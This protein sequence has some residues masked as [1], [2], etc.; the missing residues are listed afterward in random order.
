M[1]QDPSPVA[2]SS[3]PAIL[4]I[5]GSPDPADVARH[6][7]RGRMVRTPEG[8]VL[9]TYQ[10]PEM[11]IEDVSAYLRPRA[12]SF[13]RFGLDVGPP[14]DGNAVNRARRL[15]DNA[16]PR[17]LRASPAAAAMLGGSV[18]EAV[19]LGYRIRL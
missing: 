13:V 12:M 16:G 14:S 6:L 18:L 2:D 8:S 9:M 3:S 11:A 5:G 19:D 15:A 1:T 4:C 10:N 7:T 17:T